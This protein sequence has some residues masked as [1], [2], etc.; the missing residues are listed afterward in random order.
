MFIPL[1]TT[2]TQVQLRI[3]KDEVFT[4]QLTGT[5]GSEVIV[6]EQ[7]TGTGSWMPV[8]LDSTPVE[9]SATNT[10]VTFDRPAKIR[11]NKPIT[12]IAAGVSLIS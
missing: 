4:F 11:I 9:L 3:N 12:A 5:L 8:V 1:Q 2:A 10:M 6:F 7:P